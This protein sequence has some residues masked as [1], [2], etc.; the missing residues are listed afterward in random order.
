MLG[1]FKPVVFEP[2]GRRPSRWPLPRW[3]VLLL[4]GIVIGI[5]GVVIVQERYLPQRLTVDAS[6]RMR[7]AFERA[8][9]ERVR[10]NTE[11]AE[12]TKRLEAAL[13]EKK[14][15]FD[16]SA[17]SRT[18]VERLRDDVA[19]VVASLPPDP[20]GGSV[21]VRAGRF[22][23]KGGML[24]YDVVLSRERS[25]GKPF[26]GVMQLLV[27]GESARGP[28]TTIAL[29]PISLSVGSH[30]V[31][32]GSLPLPDAFKPRQA[33]IQLLDRAAGNPLGMRVFLVK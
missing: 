1:E 9:A 13:A 26:T 14:S 7:T 3:L 10:L 11:L 2:F 31:L 24:V 18:T 17:S 20:R 6:A 25:A 27:T 21:E 15:V 4:S 12:T 33:T 23:V 8:D 30:E 32:R 22:S 16:E 19:S 28:D 29:K 5:L